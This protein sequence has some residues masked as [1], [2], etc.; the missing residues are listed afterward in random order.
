[1][2]KYRCTFTGRKVGAIG[3]F[4]RHTVEVTAHTPEAAR[5]ACYETHDHISDLVVTDLSTGKAFRP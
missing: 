5:L 3:I 1:M 4:Y 2:I